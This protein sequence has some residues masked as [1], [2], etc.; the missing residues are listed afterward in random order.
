MQIQ[1]GSFDCLHN[2]KLADS[3]FIVEESE[4]PK[5][6]EFMDREEGVYIQDFSLTICSSL[7][8]SYVIT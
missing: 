8:Q 1:P 4:A 7:S 5:S 3:R 6:E 2:Y